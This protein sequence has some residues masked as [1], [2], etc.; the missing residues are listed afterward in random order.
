MLAV[1]VSNL[2]YVCITYIW[3]LTYTHEGDILLYGHIPLEKELFV[4]SV[5]AVIAGVIVICAGSLA[6]IRGRIVCGLLIMLCGLVLMKWG[7]ST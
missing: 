5:P 2:R 1:S 6:L 4:H 7:V 3:L